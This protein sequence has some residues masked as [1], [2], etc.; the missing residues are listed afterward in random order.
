MRVRLM[1]ID[2]SI[3]GSKPL[4]IDFKPAPIKPICDHWLCGNISTAPSSIRQVM[5]R[6]DLNWL[7]GWLPWRWRFYRGI[8]PP[9]KIRRLSYQDISVMPS[10]WSRTFDTDT[11]ERRCIS[12]Q[13]KKNR[14][15]QCVFEP[16]SPLLFSTWPNVNV[17]D[18]CG[19]R[20][21]INFPELV[22]P[23]NRQL[24]NNTN[25]SSLTI[26]VLY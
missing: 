2:R 17:V 13:P 21:F 26:C 23:P 4:Q 10:V 5:I 20:E 25:T 16:V 24:K 14:W 22:K 19:R 9:F 12:C 7:T 11:D 6:C 3:G 1:P 8:L 15:L 18:R